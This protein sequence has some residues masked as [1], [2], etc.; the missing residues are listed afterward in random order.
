MF[1][2]LAAL[3]LVAALSVV[4][5][6]AQAKPLDFVIMVNGPWQFVPVGNDRLYAIAPYHPTHIAF[7]WPG[8]NASM[9][10]WRDNGTY[11]QPHGTLNETALVQSDANPNI[12]ALDFPAGYSLVKKGTVHGQAPNLY[13][14]T[15]TSSIVKGVLNSPVIP[16][17]A[18]SL[19]SPYKIKTYNG[20][21]QPGSAESEIGDASLVDGTGTPVPYST[22]TVL[23]YELNAASLPGSLTLTMNGNKTSITVGTDN[24]PPIGTPRFSRSGVS[25]VLLEAPLCDD[26]TVAYYKPTGTSCPFPKKF[27]TSYD[28]PECDSVSGISFSFAAKLWSLKES[29]LFPR[30]QVDVDGNYNGKQIPKSYDLDECPL[31]GASNAQYFDD[32]QKE[33]SRY[34][35]QVAELLD[36]LEQAEMDL[37]N[38]VEDSLKALPNGKQSESIDLP[39]LFQGIGK[40]LQTVFKNGIPEEVATEFYCSC[41]NATGDKGQCKLPGTSPGKCS[42]EHGFLPAETDLMKIKKIVG[43]DKGSSDCHAAQISFNNAVQ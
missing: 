25:L 2:K 24:F 18:I 1:V 31:S 5:S 27:D 13:Q 35:S 15:A 29:A 20:G 32:H 8:T 17:Y 23:H 42:G 36:K 19:P 12:Y 30:E 34:Y 21:F 37:Q 41:F 28:D 16:R 33:L 14:T 40:D 6:H 11:T 26:G 7:L 38:E 3:L 10:N 9:M 39:T 4:P 22:W 43:Y